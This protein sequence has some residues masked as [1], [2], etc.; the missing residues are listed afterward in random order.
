MEQD[1][2]ANLLQAIASLQT[3]IAAL[4][5]NLTFLMSAVEELKK[6]NNDRRSSIDTF[7]TSTRDRLGKIES[8]L[9]LGRWLLTALIGSMLT[10]AGVRM[11]TAIAQVEH[12]A[13]Q[14]PNK[15]K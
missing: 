7:A 2:C 14:Y 6:E 15:T 3:Q 13:I 9:G 4:Q 11:F 12:P 10:F 5:S 8:D 1:Q